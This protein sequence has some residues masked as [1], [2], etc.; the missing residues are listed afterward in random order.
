MPQKLVS[1][2]ERKGT[3][4]QRRSKLQ[5]FFAAFCLG[6]LFRAYEAV[7]HNRIMH[8]RCRSLPL[9]AHSM[10]NR[11]K[12][13]IFKLK[14][15]LTNLIY[16]KAQTLN[17]TWMLFLLLG[18][19]YIGL[20]LM[21]CQSDSGNSSQ[22]ASL[23]EVVDFNFHVKPILSDRCFACHGPDEKSREADLRLD[24]EESAFAAL[25]KEG[26]HFAI[27]PGDVENSE[28]VHRIKHA[29]PE[30][31]MPPPESNLD[32][33]AYEIA[34]LEKWIEQGANWKS[35]WSFIPPEKVPPPSV[36]KSS[37]P[38]NEIDH[39]VLA[40]LEQEGMQPEAAARKEKWLRRVSFDLTGLPPTPQEL[41][42]FL[43]DESADAHERIVDRLLASPAYGERMTS[44]WLDAARYAD[45]HG[46][47]D[48]RPRTMWPWRDWVIE[49]FNANMP[50]DSFV[51]WQ[52]AG[53]LLPDA[54]YKHKLA[55]GFNRN[56]AITQEGGVV[57]EEYITEYVADRTNTTSTAFLGMT[58][59]CAR[60]HDHKYDPISQKDYYSM[61]AFFNGIDERGQI[62]YFDESPSPSMEVEREDLEDLIDFLENRIGTLEVEDSMLR[63]NKQAEF[64]TWL[65]EA[66]ENEDLDVSLSTGLISHFPMDEVSE[67]STPNRIADQ[68]IGK[69]NTGLLEV[70]EAVELSKGHEG[71]GLT[72]AGNN[73]LNIG[74][75]ADF[76]WYHPFS[77]GSWIHAP[78]NREKAAGLLVKRNGEQKRGGYELAL[79]ADGYLR[80]RL[81]HDKKKK[82]IQVKSK[83]KIPANKWVHVFA[84]YDGS[85][86]A[87]GVQ[88]YINGRLQSTRILM[89]N[90][91]HHTILNGNNLLVGNWTHRN[92]TIGDIQGFEGGTM[93]E[94]RVYDRELTPIEVMA[95]QGT[96]PHSYIA[97]LS[98]SQ[99]K[100]AEQELLLPHFL[101]HH[102]PAYT[103]IQVELFDQRRNIQPIP[104]VMIME[105]MQ[106]MRET[107]VLD[108]G[109][110][111]APTDAV[112]P[113]TP[114]NIL[115]FPT[116]LPRN[117]LG[118][119]QWITHPK[120]PLTAR[121]L[122]N[123]LWQLM[124]GQGIV[125]TPEDFGSQ[126]ALPTHPELLDWLAVEFV[127]SGW[128]IKAIL[129]KI[130]LSATYRQSSRIDAE[131]LE[132]DSENLLL[133]RGPNQRLSAEMIRDHALA[134][135]GLLSDSVGG[136]WVKSYQ[137]PGI[138]KELANQIGENKYRPGLGQELYRRSL[139]SYW[140]RTIPPPTMLT[141]DASE[142]AVCVVKRQ[143]TS[144]PLQSLVLLNDPQ[145]VEASR[146]LATSMLQLASTNDKEGIRQGFRAVTSRY[147]SQR[148]LDILTKQLA[149]EK[150]VFSREPEKAEALISI[151]QMLPDKSINPV[152]LA[153]WTVLANTLLNLD[154]AKMKS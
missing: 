47:Q 15:I 64:E 18:G 102:V 55:T 7:L 127:E 46:Y 41:D 50:Y 75:K 112:Q 39:F 40:R 77:L 149:A 91:D 147:P 106:E 88:L 14:A 128:N 126:G 61:F 16:M 152:E 73:F 118:L 154:E 2:E 129:R 84:T 132:R 3:E 45:S 83:S 80:M 23:P 85:G 101:T 135:S 78:S 122:V 143:T 123:R 114:S 150:R 70:L 119:A 34:L 42:A 93:D 121:V 72:F 153:S 120:H 21:A 100:L 146:L 124:F 76:E 59:E 30:E 9:F 60:C 111:D 13:D 11:R 104:K 95:I 37:W 115:D 110:Y 125:S 22:P 107:F 28:L 44:I 12:V 145:Y 113:N 87:G 4:T 69:M 151:G 29:D 57:N 131:K 53:D 109:A 65:T 6:V 5:L 140:K 138:W 43:L 31:V 20:G 38:E 25:D 103:S 58:M 96:D 51:V 8:K 139:Y 26:K 133:A 94:V 52:L 141:F 74:D 89:D 33:S 97:S 117:R 68:P 36:K 27:S 81:I 98:S 116:D 108:R 17:R 90:L 56:H 86:K 92:R 144:T 48:D 134:V 105:E 67:L 130:A 24:M 99:R 54:G 137:P 66:F 79:T 1:W 62:N 32:L 35:H 136:K 82:E 49:S 148:E 19:M 10:E 63:V 71:N 142:R